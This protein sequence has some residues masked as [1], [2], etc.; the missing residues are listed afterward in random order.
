MDILTGP[1]QGSPANLFLIHVGE[2]RL[3]GPHVSFFL[4]GGT[5]GTTASCWIDV[6]DVCLLTHT[7]SIDTTPNKIEKLEARKSWRKHRLCHVN[8]ILKILFGAYQTVSSFHATNRKLDRQKSNPKTI[9]HWGHRLRRP[10]VPWP[11]CSR[12]L[13]PS[14][15][16]CR[17][18]RSPPV[19]YSS[20][21]ICRWHGVGIATDQW[22]GGAGL[23]KFFKCGFQWDF[24]IGS[25]I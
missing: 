24:C 7:H 8:E 14:T 12:T 20:W 10:Q 19:P 13:W 18:Y 4:S 15:R 3:V 22:P 23:S 6:I 25:M 11:H 5:W 2:R 16:C 17:W 1:K 9:F 21:G